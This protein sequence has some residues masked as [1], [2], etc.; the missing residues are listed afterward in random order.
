MYP[1]TFSV[2]N[3]KLKVMAT[4]GYLVEPAEVDYI[5]LHSGER[6]DFLLE[7]TEENGNYTG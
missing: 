7:A 2:D 4:D 1:S 5:A 3:H 6:Y